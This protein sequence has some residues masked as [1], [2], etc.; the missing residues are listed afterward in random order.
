MII[1]P[2]AEAPDGPIFYSLLCM[3]RV[4][5]LFMSC[6]SKFIIVPSSQL[7]PDLIA[8]DYCAGCQALR[9]PPMASIPQGAFASYKIRAN[10]QKEKQN[11]DWQGKYN[12][13]KGSS[14]G[15]KEYFGLPQFNGELLAI[16]PAKYNE[17]LMK[18]IWGQ[19]NRY[20]VHNFK[21]IKGDA[22]A[23]GRQQLPQVD[24]MIVKSVSACLTNPTFLVN[25]SG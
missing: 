15:F 23:Y 14:K 16:S 11:N 17:K 10:A 9:R 20:S 6:E 2:L 19:Y 12:D 4:P 22:V 3:R 7:L 5:S 8:V 18:S 1:P 24:E 25:K 21:Q 13:T